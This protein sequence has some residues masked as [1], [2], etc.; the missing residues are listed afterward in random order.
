MKDDKKKLAVVGALFL[1]ILA[2]GA[3][4]FIGG[5]SPA[6]SKPSE[7]KKAAEAAQAETGPKNPMF[8][9]ALAERDPFTPPEPPKTAETTPVPGQPTNP[10][11]PEPDKAGL[12]GP[13]LPIPTEFSAV[14]IPPRGHVRSG[15][16]VSRPAGPASVS[17]TGVV[18]GA[19]PAA[20]LQDNS[21]HQFVLSVGETR[22]GVRVLRVTENS[23]TVSDHGSR[24]RLTVGDNPNGK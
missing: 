24:R 22:D 15:P 23:V 3:F 9:T 7:K 20:V 14:P 10:V 17:A 13:I 8:A 4:N 19:S 5:S 6:P 16:R 12:N 2:V 18:L 21:G 11:K 1:V